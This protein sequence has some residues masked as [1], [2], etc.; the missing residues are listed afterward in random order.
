MSLETERILA[1]LDTEWP[2]GAVHLRAA[3]NDRNAEITRLEHELKNAQNVRAGVAYLLSLFD[4]VV[5][6]K[7]AALAEIARLKDGE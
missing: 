7:D 3:L 6:E 4:R 5:A 1:T 2:I